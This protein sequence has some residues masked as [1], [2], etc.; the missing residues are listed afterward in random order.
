MNNDLYNLLKSSYKKNDEAEKIGL[1]QGLL[2]DKN[3]SNDKH[4]VFIDSNNDAKVVFTGTKKKNDYKTDLAL[5]FGLQKYTNRFQNAD[6]L[7]KNVRTKYPNT[8]ITS[9]GDSLGGSLAEHSKADKK[10][11]YNKGVGF[12]MI[13]KKIPKNQLDIRA[14]YDPI[15][16]LS[17]TQRH[18]GKKITLS[19]KYLNPH[20]Y[21]NLNDIEN[22]YIRDL[23]I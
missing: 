5:L 17:K 22:N 4:K 6:K 10:I 13:N 8:Q 3:L 14:K 9:L 11:T 1:R 19:S 20:K 16:L 23:I 18:K 7:I 2:M 21:K 12:G 15:S